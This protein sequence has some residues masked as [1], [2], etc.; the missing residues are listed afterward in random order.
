MTLPACMCYMCEPS[1]PAQAAVV[2]DRHSPALAD[3]CFVWLTTSRCR[4]QENCLIFRWQ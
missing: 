3:V 4:C 2:D 1:V